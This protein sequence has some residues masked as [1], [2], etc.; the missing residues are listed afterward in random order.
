MD[1]AGSNFTQYLAIT[2]ENPL[3]K[4]TKCVPFFIMRGNSTGTAFKNLIKIRE[5]KK[6]I[7]E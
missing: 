2:K 6:D 5:F 3:K 7:R 4:N 1:L